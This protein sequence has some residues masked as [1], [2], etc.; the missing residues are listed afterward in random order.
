MYHSRI[1]SNHFLIFPTTVTEREHLLGINVSLFEATE[2]QDMKTQITLQHPGI[3][4]CIHP[5]HIGLLH[6]YKHLSNTISE[7]SVQ[8]NTTRN[9]GLL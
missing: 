7:V 6:L 3:K 5:Q 2:I 1:I 9:T 8:E 4:V